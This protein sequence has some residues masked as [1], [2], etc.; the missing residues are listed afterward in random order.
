MDSYKDKRKSEKDV[1]ES[2][3]SNPENVQSLFWLAVI[4]MVNQNLDA[5]FSAYLIN[6]FLLKI[7]KYRFVWISPSTR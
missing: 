3:E 1:K 5:I 4:G 2:R 7:K 6:H